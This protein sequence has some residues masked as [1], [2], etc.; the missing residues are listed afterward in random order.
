M[1]KILLSVCLAVSTFYTMNSAYAIDAKYRA[2]LERSGCTQ[3]SELQGCD[4]NK[5][6]AENSKAGFGTDKRIIS[7]TYAGKWIAKNS[8]SGQ[9]VS[10]IR[11]DNK[12]N[13]WVNG[14]KV[15]SKRS[16]GELIFKKGF[17]SYKLEGDPTQQDKSYWTDSD[18]KTSGPIVRK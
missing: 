9:T 6:K 8:N 2:K 10:N 3:V 5:S 7:N 12:E 13:V 15:K 18:A 14:Q 17:I 4:V 16:D 11:V 1:N